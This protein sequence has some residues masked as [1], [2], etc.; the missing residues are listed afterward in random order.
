MGGRSTP[1]LFLALYANPR[2]P[3]KGVTLWRYRA[4]V[5]WFREKTTR[6]PT[7]SKGRFLLEVSSALALQRAK[8]LKTF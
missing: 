3:L 7:W 6:G 4:L 5:G 2:A 8:E 1:I